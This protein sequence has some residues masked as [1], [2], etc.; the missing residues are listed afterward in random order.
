[1]TYNALE[2]HPYATH[3]GGRLDFV[4]RVARAC[5]HERIWLC[6]PSIVG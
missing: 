5:A 2:S 6:C 4:A 3:F 1:M